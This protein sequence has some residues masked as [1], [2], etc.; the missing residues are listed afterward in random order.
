MYFM[1]LVPGVDDGL[2]TGGL[3]DGQ[4]GLD[5]TEE[6]DRVGEAE[7]RPVAENELGHEPLLL[8]VG[9]AAFLVGELEFRK[10]N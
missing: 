8:V 1:F 6:V 4:S 3:V 5:E 2:A 7:F 9:F 10:I